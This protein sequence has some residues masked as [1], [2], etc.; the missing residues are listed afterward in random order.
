M[1][2]RAVQGICGRR[3]RRRR[4]SRF[5]ACPRPATRK[6]TPAGVPFLVEDGA[7]GSPAYRDRV[8]WVA[9]ACAVA[10][11][12]G[13]DAPG[14]ASGAAAG[15]AG[16]GGRA[17]GSSRHASWSHGY[18]CEISLG[19]RE[20]GT[21][22]RHSAAASEG[23]GHGARRARTG[24]HGAPRRARR[25]AKRAEIA[26]DQT[27]S[28]R[29]GEK[30]THGDRNKA[31]IRLQQVFAGAVPRP[32]ASWDAPGAPVTATTEWCGGRPSRSTSPQRRT[33][34]TDRPWRRRGCRPR[35]TRSGRPGSGGRAGCRPCPS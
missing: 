14:A 35:R 16:A 13:P 4:T 6:G 21:K 11:R 24:L 32:G 29:A 25:T 7:N 19:K 26:S 28:G 8:T 1:G 18:A 22:C 31:A 15:C 17:G 23:Q 2:G 5:G 33:R 3:A 20:R 10:G 34:S 9:A 30:S 27:I 12:A